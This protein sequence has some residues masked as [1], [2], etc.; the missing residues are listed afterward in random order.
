VLI[1]LVVNACQATDPGGGEVVIHARAERGFHV[2]EVIDHG[3]GLSRDVAGRLFTPFVTDKREGHGLGLAI[4]Q[5]IAVA[6]GGRIEVHPNAGG[7]GMTF[8][9][10]LPEATS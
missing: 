7:P 5:N 3:R 1:N 9:V 10:W 2:I 4:S 8:A 6:H